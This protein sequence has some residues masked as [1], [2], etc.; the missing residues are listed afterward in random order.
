MLHL[1]SPLLSQAAGKVLNLSGLSEQESP[2]SASL[3]VLEANP[4]QSDEGWIERML[5]TA[6]ENQK[7]DLDPVLL[8]GPVDWAG[9]TL[10]PAQ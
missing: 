8:C 2:A 5:A 7:V 6:V 3:P 10:Q 1:S 9:R 4:C